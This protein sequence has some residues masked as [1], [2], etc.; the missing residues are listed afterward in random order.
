MATAAIIDY[1]LGN[2]RS[3]RGAVERLGY[4][5]VVSS[6]SGD[7]AAAD[8]LILPGVGAFGDGMRRLYERDLIRPLNRLVLEDKKPILGICLGAQLMTNSSCEF[9]QHEGL[10]WVDASVE[11]LPV[12]GL[13][14]PHVG[15]NDL[16][17]VRDSQL[18]RDMSSQPL[19]YYVHS[20]HIH[21]HDESLVTGRCEYGASFTASFERG[22]IFG[23]QFHPEKSQAEG[24]V[25]LSNF[26]GLASDE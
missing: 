16:E 15:W 2:V 11:R 12:N 23:S 4:T 18:F 21:C 25:F 22:N 1:G 17:I 6:A 3:V 7:L 13:P 14:L 5:A 9:G 8:A 10:R 19:V 26:L 24:L 20:F